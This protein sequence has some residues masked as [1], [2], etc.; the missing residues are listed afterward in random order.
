MCHSPSPTKCLKTANPWTNNWV[1]SKVKDKLIILYRHLCVSINDDF[2][3]QIESSWFLSFASRNYCFNMSGAN[4]STGVQIVPHLTFNSGSRA[5]AWRI[6]FSCIVQKE[7][8]AGDVR[9][10]TFSGTYANIPLKTL[11]TPK[12][13]STQNLHIRK[14]C[15]TFATD[16]YAGGYM[17]CEKRFAKGLSKGR[18]LTY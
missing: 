10:Y 9:K 4:I 3:Y 7:C 12:T 6:I 18:F 8:A 17:S 16:S 11:K 14:F 2:V 1:C 13:F 15:C 5:Y